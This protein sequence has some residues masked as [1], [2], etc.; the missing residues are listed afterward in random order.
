MVPH[1]TT[2]HDAMAPSSLQLSCTCLSVSHTGLIP[3]SWTKL[4]ALWLTCLRRYGHCERHRIPSAG[5]VK[6][7]R[8]FGIGSLLW[9]RVHLLELLHWDFS[10]MKLFWNQLQFSLL[11]LWISGEL[12]I[13]SSSYAALNPLSL[14]LFTSS[15]SIYHNFSFPYNPLV[16]FS[17]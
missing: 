15:L 12:L 2:T 9:E 1:G 17:L 3:A 5:W 14:S 11:F 16:F 4:L 10:L 7:F 8:E 13:Y 6:A